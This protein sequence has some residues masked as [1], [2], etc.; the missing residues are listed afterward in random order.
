MVIFLEGSA[1]ESAE[2]ADRTRS[3]ASDTALSGRPTIE[4]VGMPGAVAH[5]TSTKRASTPSNATV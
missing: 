5:C 1:M 2:S 4:N 3:R